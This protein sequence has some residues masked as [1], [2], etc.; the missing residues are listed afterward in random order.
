MQYACYICYFWFLIYSFSQPHS[1]T[2]V[3]MAPL[4]WHGKQINY[5]L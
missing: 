2:G 3:T 1:L 4:L 5:V